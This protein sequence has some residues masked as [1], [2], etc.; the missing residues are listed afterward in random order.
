M[1]AR[2]QAEILLDNLVQNYLSLQER[3]GSQ[4]LISVVKANAYGHGIELVGPKLQEAGCKLFAVTDAWEGASLRTLLGDQKNRRPAQIFLLSGIVGKTDARIA[5][6]MRLCPVLS[7]EAQFAHLAEAAFEGPCWL[8]FD[9][10]MH[11]LGFY[12][13][14]PALAAAEARGLK[15]EGVLSHFACADEPGHPLN[16]HQLA[17]FAEVLESL[18][19]RYLYSLCNSAGIENELGKD[20]PPYRGYVRAGISLFGCYNT[21]PIEAQKNG[22]RLDPVMRL[23]AKVL[24]RKHLEPGDC[25]SYGATF[26]ASHP[27]EVAVI[28]AGYA[29][30]VPRAFSN[31]GGVWALGKECPILGRVCMDLCIVDVS[32][33]GKK[34]PEDVLFWG[35]G[36]RA[37]KA[38]LR[39]GLIPYE[40]FTGVGKRVPRVAQLNQS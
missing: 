7:S 39:A 10:G 27:M 31:C 29:D 37:E 2:V 1:E 40:L 18:G 30:G 32:G 33:L 26:E 6:E 15:V 22:L 11:R 35:E 36:I 13:L 24:Q 14:P 34:V 12:A 19:D 38:A 17:S 16:A 21:D 28:G 4:S 23:R 8:K 25:V 5:Q 3:A 9:S 20:L